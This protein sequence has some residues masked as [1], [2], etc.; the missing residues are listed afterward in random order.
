MNGTLSLDKEVNVLLVDDRPENLIALE[1]ILASSC[2]NFV[3]CMSGEEA[4]KFLIHE[5]CA[6]ILLDVQM[7]GINGY[8]TAKLIKSREKNKDTPIIFITAINHDPEHVYAGYS[9]GAVDYIF[10]PFDPDVLKSKVDIF[11]EMHTINKRLIN[12]TRQLNLH[13]QQLEAANEELQRVAQELRRAEALAKVIGETSMD[14]M[15]IFNEKGAMLTINPAVKIMFGYEPDELTGRSVDMLFGTP[16]L[17]AYAAHSAGI[18]EQT[19]KSGLFEIEAFRRTGISFPAE[20]QVHEAYVENRRLYACTVRE[21]TER[22]KQLADLRHMALHDTLTGLPNRTM[23]YD[24]MKTMIRQAD[25][26]TNF[27]LVLFD[28]NHFKAINDTLGHS[29]GDAFLQAL[30]KE[31]Q[32][33]L[34]DDELIARL[35]GDEFAMLLPNRDRQSIIEKI[36]AL[37]K[38][39][40][41]PYYI[42]GITLAVG[43]SMGVSL[44]PEYG[45]N[46]N[47]LMQYADIAMYM[48]KR[49]GS[50]YALYDRKQDQNNPFHL[51]LM[52][53]L[54]DAVTNG[55]I[56]LHYQPKIRIATGDIVGVEALL[57][58]HHPQF[59]MVPPSEFIPIA[60]QIGFINLLTYWVLEEAIRQSKSWEE[61]GIRMKVAVNLSVRSLQDIAFPANTEKLLAKYRLKPELL[62]LEITESFLMSDT[63]R[64]M[65]VLTELQSLGIELSIDDFGTGFSSLSYLQHLPVSQV[66]IDKSFVLGMTAESGNHMIVRSIITLAKNLR[67]GV[68]AEGVENMETLAELES[69]G[70]D[71][72][73][74]YFVSKPIS[75][76]EIGEWMVRHSHNGKWKR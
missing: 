27:A 73:Q 8:E 33:Q 38:L 58:W 32:L 2:A 60:E 29:Y 44:F 72:A 22:K 20:V 75:S 68:V 28:L 66:K 62:H 6:L 9:V 59:G 46:P 54:R 25:N 21:I 14:V 36:E 63:V 23:L 34:E 24:K 30:G 19:G 61:S 56:S 69:L 5:E 40:E 64:A 26:H 31:V 51:V 43:V 16:L 67:L 18:G 47:S 76:A 10:K 7:P 12:Q 57:R 71:E 50:G 11:L 74:G 4:L 41:R 65:E 37:Q 15:V 52:S 35:G 13:K 49:R 17:S 3:K 70:C 48:A 55:Q 42:E 45:D 1:G 53:E 39:I